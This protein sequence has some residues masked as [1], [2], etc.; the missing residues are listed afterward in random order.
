MTTGTH[1]VGTDF[2]PSKSEQ[3][4]FIKTKTAE[5]IDYLAELSSGRTLPGAR[6][7]SIAMTSYEEAAMWAVKA[8]TKKEE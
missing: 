5:L 7:A 4:D 1:R 6:E 8:V 3:V 2:N